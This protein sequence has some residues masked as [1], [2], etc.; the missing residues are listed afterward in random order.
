MGNEGP[1]QVSRRLE[2]CLRTGDVEELRDLYE[3]GAVFA[4]YDGIVEG[5]DAIRAVHQGF[6][7]AGL[8]LNLADSIV[9]EAGNIAL[10]HWTWSVQHSDGSTVEGASAEVLRRQTDGSWKFIIDNSDGAA[11]VGL[12]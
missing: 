4:D 11:L 1:E 10:V 7:A 6:I 5:W 9:L 2:R 8:E 12:L 3:P